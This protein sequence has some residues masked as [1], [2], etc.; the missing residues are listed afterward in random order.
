MRGRIE[1]VYEQPMNEQRQA[2]VESLRKSGIVE[3]VARHTAQL[4]VF[5][6]DIRI[7]FASC[8]G[9]ETAF[10]RQDRKEVVMCYDLLERFQ[11]LDEA[12]RCFAMEGLPESE[13]NA[14]LVR[15]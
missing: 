5:P 9:Y 15:P 2:L 11:Y 1:V 10:W 8:F 13:L 3:L 7:V 12:R 14:C 4:H 6:R